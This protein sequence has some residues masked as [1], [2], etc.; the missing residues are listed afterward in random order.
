MTLAIFDLQVAL[1]FSTK[2]CI[3]WLFSVGEDAKI[4][5]QDPGHG[6]NLGFPI[7]IILTSIDLQVALI[8][9]IKFCVD[10]C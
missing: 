5:F 7:G 8:L 6:G 1:V 3:N 2:F 9:P 10:L 4:D